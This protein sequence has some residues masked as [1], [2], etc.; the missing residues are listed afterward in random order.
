ME[1]G[2]AQR[3]RYQRI[4]RRDDHDRGGLAAGERREER[5]ET[6]KREKSAESGPE[7][8]GR[9]LF[10]V[11]AFEDENNE[12]EGE[13]ADGLKQDGLARLGVV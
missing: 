7:E 13:H 9:V 1:K 8:A 4:K 12:G 11:E 3:D 5:E 10:D 2:D 6:D